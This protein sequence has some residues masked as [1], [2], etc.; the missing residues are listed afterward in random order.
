MTWLHR[1]AVSILLLAVFI[2]PTACSEPIAATETLPT[3]IVTTSIWADVVDNLLCDQGANEI[4][5]E[6]L[7]D[8]DADPHT[9]EVHLGDRAELSDAALI[10]VNGA[11]LEAATSDTIE[12]VRAEGVP[13][14]DLAVEVNEMVVDNDPH[15]WLDPTIV[16]V[17]IPSLAAGLIDAGADEA[18]VSS[19]A[20]SYR[21]SLAQLDAD[22]SAQLDAVPPDQR[23]LAAV[24]GLGYF[25]DHYGLDV[26]ATVEPGT[27]HAAPSPAALAATIDVMTRRG[28][29]VLATDINHHS[30]N[31]NAVKAAIDDLVEVP[32]YTAGLGPTDDSDTYLE[33]MA[34]N[35]DR[36]AA[37]LGS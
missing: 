25:A 28:V 32:L 19:C 22:I 31:V 2:A 21:Q 26:V 13:V 35:A 8:T 23:Q 30:D 10:I 4:A 9:A 3:V 37:A 34:L 18:A 12:A 16:A 20:D 7:F 29:T 15:F 17:A 33:V 1:C 5:V 14:L 6:G 11:G 36:L 24:H 27:D